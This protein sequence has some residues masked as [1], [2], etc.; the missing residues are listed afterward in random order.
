MKVAKSSSHL[1]FYKNFDNLR[2]KKLNQ[3]PI[4]ISQ[5]TL[6]SSIDLN[7]N[8]EKVSQQPALQQTSTFKIFELKKNAGKNSLRLSQLPETRYADS[9][10]SNYTDKSPVSERSSRLKKNTDYV[11]VNSNSSRKLLRLY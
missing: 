4:D 3:Q 9:N 2:S 11:I 6:F 5:T 7:L 10:R 8:F 1:P